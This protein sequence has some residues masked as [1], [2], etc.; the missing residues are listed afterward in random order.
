MWGEFSPLG[1]G[2]VGDLALGG[3]GEGDGSAGDV[4]SLAE[5]DLSRA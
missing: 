2:E 5:G 1:E 4:V 3:F